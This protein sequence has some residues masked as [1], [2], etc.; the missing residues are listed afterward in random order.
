M[1]LCRKK[2]FTYIADWIANANTSMEGEGYLITY[3]KITYKFVILKPRSSAWVLDPWAGPRTQPKPRLRLEPT[4]FY[5][6]SHIW[7]QDLLKF[8]FFMS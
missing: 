2:E 5:L 8:M 7:S 3:S 6:K 1:K 4:V